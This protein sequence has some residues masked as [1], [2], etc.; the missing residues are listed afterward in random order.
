MKL[1]NNLLLMLIELFSKT[2]IIVWV[3]YLTAIKTNLCN[4]IIAKFLTFIILMLW[5]IIPSVIE[6]QRRVKE[7]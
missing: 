4:H 7:K 6:F 2:L 3:I 5:I 1:M